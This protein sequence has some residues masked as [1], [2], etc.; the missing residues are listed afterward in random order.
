MLSVV[1]VEDSKLL[2]ERLV[3][4]ITDPGRIEVVGLA[5][6]EKDAIE[7]LVKG[8]A[9]ALILD[10]YLAEGNGLNVLREVRRVRSKAELTIIVLTNEVSAGCRR[11][12]IRLGADYFLDKSIEIDRLND[13]LSDISKRA[14]SGA[15]SYSPPLH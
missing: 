6:K 8:D 15:G 12:S 3:E 10:I 11:E 9:D 13:I 7:L 14:A 1:I 5:D 2:V 4:T